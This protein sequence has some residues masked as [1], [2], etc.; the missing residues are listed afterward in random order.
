MPRILAALLLLAPLSQSALANAPLPPS[1][2]ARAWLLLDETSG[3]MLAS[4]NADGRIE[5]ASLTKLMTAYIAFSALRQ[6]SIALGQTITVSERAFRASGSRMFVEPQKPVTV[7]EL[8]H[9]L[10]VQ[11]GND[12]CIALAET[13]AGSEAAFVERMNDEAK[14]LGMK[15]THFANSSGMPDAHH[16]STTSDLALLAAALIRDYPEYYKFYSEREYRYNDITQ[17]NR[18]RLLWLDPNV[19]GMKTGHTQSAGYCLVASARR[20]DRR[21]VSVL[22][23]APT[24]RVRN[25]E[26]QKLLNFGFLAYD[27]LRLYQKDQEISRLS[28]WQGSEKQLRAGV[29]ADLYVTVPAGMADKLQAEIVSDQ[30]LIAPL[31]AGERV[32]TLRVALDGKPFGEY[33]VVALESVAPAS[34]FRRAWDGIALWF[35]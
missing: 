16:Y 35:K 31:A 3:Q 30:P 32:A 34:I 20:G 9:G 29:A 10:I 27:A 4:R 19:D 2:T 8:L 25:E 1:L 24:E 15:D 7:Q 11:S 22:V 26:S 5:P 33:P 23:G 14:R 17:L 18:N 21:L 12:A 6:K 28:V 13:I